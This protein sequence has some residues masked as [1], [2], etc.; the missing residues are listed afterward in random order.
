MSVTFDIETQTY[1]SNIV[2]RLSAMLSNN[3]YGPEGKAVI[4]ETRGRK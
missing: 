4:E 1:I 2:K 3:D